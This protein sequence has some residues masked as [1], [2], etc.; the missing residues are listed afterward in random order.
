[1][2][3]GERLNGGSALFVWHALEEPEQDPVGLLTPSKK[4]D[5][6]H[7]ERRPLNETYDQLKKPPVRGGVRHQQRDN[8]RLVRWGIGWGAGEV[9]DAYGSEKATRIGFFD[10]PLIEWPSA[11][12]SLKTHSKE[13]TV[14]WR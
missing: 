5:E 8:E 1:M 7:I 6:A 3:C 9:A 13:R 12:Q 11:S 2:M 14:A 4:P 10:Q